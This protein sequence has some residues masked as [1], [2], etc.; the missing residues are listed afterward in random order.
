V[1]TKKPT[2]ETTKTTVKFKFTSDEP[3]ST[4]QCKLDKKPFKTCTSPRNVKVKVGK[5]K[6]R[7]LAIDSAGNVDASAAKAKFKVIDWGPLLPQESGEAGSV[8]TPDSA[9]PARQMARAGI[10]PATPRFSGAS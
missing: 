8:M 9:L 2:K 3:G 4:F 6:F 5:H 10:E 1:I 7:V